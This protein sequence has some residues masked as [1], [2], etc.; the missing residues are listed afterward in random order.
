MRI[1]RGRES[2]VPTCTMGTALGD[3][4]RSG[5]RSTAHRVAWSLE[6]LQTVKVNVHRFTFNVAR[7]AVSASRSS[8]FAKLAATPGWAG[9][10]GSQTNGFPGFPP[11][12]RRP[13]CAHSLR[14]HSRSRPQGR[15]HRPPCCLPQGCCHLTSA[16]EFFR[17]TSHRARMRAAAALATSPADS[18]L[19]SNECSVRAHET[20]YVMNLEQPPRA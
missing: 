15:Y 17:A 16:A 13:R 4:G 11:T 9:R 8:L 6:V 5:G 19:G 20:G 3:C 1:R 7:G 10:L 12:R 14:H 2:H 18:T